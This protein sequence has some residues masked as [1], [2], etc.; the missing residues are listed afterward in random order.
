MLKM[1]VLIVEI[2]DLRRGIKF[3]VSRSDADDPNVA[4]RTSKAGWQRPRCHRMSQLSS[5]I[6]SHN[7]WPS[8]KAIIRTRSKWTQSGIFFHWISE[9][10]QTNITTV[11]GCGLWW[12]PSPLCKGLL[13]KHCRNVIKCLSSLYSVGQ[14]ILIFIIREISLELPSSSQP[15]YF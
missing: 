14:Q 9:R 7:S 1:T 15:N 3:K 11:K 2:L 13:K 8:L 10:R 12:L 5:W 4:A 6:G